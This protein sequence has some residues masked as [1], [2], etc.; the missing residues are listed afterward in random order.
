MHH[1]GTSVG[2]LVVSLDLAEDTS[3]GAPQQS[4]ARLMALFEEQGIPATWALSQPGCGL[5][6]ERI[7]SASA[8][9][10]I[11]LICQRDWAGNVAGRTV[12][13]RQL[14]RTFGGGQASGCLCIDARHARR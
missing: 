1:E 11:A 10:E 8:G 7:L 12:F 9:H 4:Q 13:A 6:T 5:I 3:T 2:T 14:M